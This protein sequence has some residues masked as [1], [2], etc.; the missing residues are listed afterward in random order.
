MDAG[1]L[2]HVDHV[3]DAVGGVAAGAVAEVAIGQAEL[4]GGADEP[5]IGG[6]EDG[7]DA[8]LDAGV[9]GGGGE[10]AQVDE[11][12]DVGLVFFEVGTE[13]FEE[14]AVVVFAFDDVGLAAHGNV[15]VFEAVDGEAV[16]IVGI[17]AEI[18]GDD[19][20]GFA[21][22]LNG[23]AGD[24]ADVVAAAAEFARGGVDDD[25]RA[26]RVVR[27]ELMCGEDD[28]HGKAIRLPRV[29]GRGR[30]FRR[31]RRD[32]GRARWRRQGPGF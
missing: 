31:G 25:L 5:E 23:E 19:G 11:V 15:G 10:A 21:F 14:E 18:V 27:Q 16:E 12:D 7:G 26:R 1:R 17:E 24:D 30:V 3:L 2:A 29:C 28:F 4:V 6:G 32:T 13:E 22:A 20:D 8:A 9:D